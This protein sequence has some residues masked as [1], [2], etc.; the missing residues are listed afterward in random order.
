MRRGSPSLVTGIL[1]VALA[2]VLWLLRVEVQVQYLG[3]H[4]WVSEVLDPGFD[5]R[6]ARLDRI[7]ETGDRTQTPWLIEVIYRDSSWK[8]RKWAEMAL[9]RVEGARATPVL[10]DLLLHAPLWR[11][12][13]KPAELLG[14]YGDRTC[15]PALIQQLDDYDLL[16]RY[17][18]AKSLGKLRERSAVPRLVR[19][20]HEDPQAYPRSGAALAL[21]EIGDPTAWPHLVRA[22]QD[23]H[24]EVRCYAVQALGKSGQPVA[25]PA[26]MLLADDPDPEVRQQV[27]QALETLVEVRGRPALER[28]RDD[29]DP[30]VQFRA[31]RALRALEGLALPPAW[32]PPPA[33]RGIQDF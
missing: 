21:G 12:R 11:D 19:M 2:A 4:S 31:R 30:R 7:L 3:L 33:S 18:C 9:A 25:G 8:T 5:E 15:V 28:L 26:V 29:A 20:L 23:D 22:L 14:K 27:C 16:V 24:A 6:M 17:W 13:V 10:V 32:S 1:L